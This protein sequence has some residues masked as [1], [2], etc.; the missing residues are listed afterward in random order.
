V[1]VLFPVGIESRALGRHGDVVGERGND[2]VVPLAVD[3]GLQRVG[4]EGGRQC[5]VGNAGVHGT[6]PVG[7]KG[8]FYARAPANGKGRRPPPEGPPRQRYTRWMPAPCTIRAY[9]CISARK[10]AAVWSGGISVIVLPCVA[11]AAFPSG[12]VN[13]WVKAWY[14]RRTAASG[15]CAGATTANHPAMS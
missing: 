2:F 10:Y 11:M 9:F 1:G 4:I 13:P 7:A 6:G 12:A 3:E 5:V 15:K 14:T 8:T